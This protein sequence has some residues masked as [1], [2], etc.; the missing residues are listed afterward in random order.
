MQVYS[1]GCFDTYYCQ[2][3]S[4]FERLFFEQ[5]VNQFMYAP[6]LGSDVVNAIAAQLQNITIRTFILEMK[7]CDECGE[8]LGQSGADRYQY[9]IDHYLSNVHYLEALSVQYPFLF[10]NIQRCKEQWLQCLLEAVGRFEKDKNTLND[11]LYAK[12]ICQKILRINGGSSDSHN[13]G[14]HVLILE[15]DNGER[16]VYKPRNV[17]IES[18][19]R[20]FAE[21]IFSAMGIA[22][23][24]PQV[25][26]GGDYGWAEWVETRACE[27]YEQLAG[28]Y[29]RNGVLLC[30]SYLLGTRDIHYENLIAHGEFPVIV[31]LE[32]GISNGTILHSRDESQVEKIYRQSVLHTGIL[33]LFMWD[34]LG[35]GINVSAINGT[36]GQLM[37]VYMPFLV[38]PGTVDMHIEYRQPQMKEAKN[39]AKLNG[40]FIQPYDFLSC[41]LKGFTDAYR[42]IRE[43]QSTVKQ[44]LEAFSSVKIRFLLRNTQQYSMLLTT[45]YHPRFME[46]QEAHRGL[47]GKLESLF[48][49]I[50]DSDLL[51]WMSRQEIE[52]MTRGDVPYFWYC[53]SEKFLCSGTGKR[54]ENFFVTTAMQDI[55]SRLEGWGEEDLLRQQKLIKASMFIGKKTSDKQNACNAVMRH[56]HEKG[57][58]IIPDKKKIGL[59]M[60]EKLHDLL[61]EGAIWS[62]NKEEIGWISMTVAGYQERGYLIRP[63]NLYLYD[64]IGGIAILEAMLYHKTGEEKYQRILEILV[65]MLFRYTDEL[66]QKQPIKNLPTGAFAGEASI[67]YVYQIL[68]SINNDIRYLKYMK[69][70]CCILS[71]LLQEDTEFDLLGGNAGAVLVLLNAYELTEEKEYLNL[72]K[73]A[74]NFLLNTATDY[75]WGIG[76]VNPSVGRALT[77][78]AHGSAGMVLAFTRLYAATKEDVYQNTAK[79]VFDFEQ[80][81]YVKSRRD[82][83]DLR[84]AEEE[85]EQVSHAA[86]WC[87]GWMGIVVSRIVASQYASGDLKMKLEN[88]RW[89]HLQEWEGDI[90]SK[91]FC[92][93]H[94]WMGNAALIH[95]MNRKK[96]INAHKKAIMGLWRHREDIKGL[97]AVQECE[98]Y[99]LMGGITGISMGCICEPERLADLLM[100]EVCMRR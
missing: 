72:A 81:Y 23:W 97:L 53:A 48:S 35:E 73:M 32:T 65:Q 28:Y 98:N 85:Q 67:A 24:W 41:L 76:W 3:I 59:L 40:E 10:E 58:G 39:L 78:L 19:Y 14:K 17:A 69:K 55:A 68:Y 80:H 25:L 87:H 90:C 44:Q 50:E 47:L 49:W 92:L 29:E 71:K 83:T 46:N 60:A 8:L 9:Y 74:G 18:A 86:A 64:G 70:H 52:E 37:P 6:S 2:E 88:S 38:N 82:W 56:N 12:N 95:V 75:G 11:R 27:S 45:S 91:S 13:G 22:F 36:G 62:Q 93:C 89:K 100:V 51:K 5:C 43:H 57:C 33:P 96:A 54:L 77:G 63:M 31:D 84:F 79:R 1:N 99:G 15:L 30:I 16:L 42:Y 20:E 34:E 26:D 61:M 7:V 94:G 66:S 21:N 4:V